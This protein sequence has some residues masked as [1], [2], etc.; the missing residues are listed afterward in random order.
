MCGDPLP[1]RGDDHRVSMGAGGA[2]ER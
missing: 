1:L 2:E